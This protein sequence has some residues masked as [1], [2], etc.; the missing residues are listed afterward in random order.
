MNP[1]S[2]NDAG[3]KRSTLLSLVLKALHAG[4]AESL[5][6]MSDLLKLS[7]HVI[8]GLMDE[9]FRDDLV[10]VT[11]ANESSGIPILTYSLTATGRRLAA[12]ALE[13]NAYVGPAPVG[14]KTYRDQAIVNPLHNERLEPSRIRRALADLVLTD[15]VVNRLGPAINTCRSMLLYGPPGNGKSS[16]ARRIG[17]M[18]SNTVYVPYCVEIEGQ[19]VKIFDPAI[20]EE[21][22]PSPTGR[23]VETDIR[24]EDFD[25]RWVVCRRPVVITGG[26]FSLDMLDLRYI[27]AAKFYE[28]PL[29]IKAMGGTFVID[30]FG[31]QL[32]GPKDILNRWMIPLEEKLDYLKFITGA[33]VSLPFE[34]LVI[35]CTNLAPRD[36]MDAAFLRRIPYKIKLS[37]PSVD[38]YREI[39]RRAA[40]E[41]ALQISAADLDW[42][43]VE[44]QEQR[45]LPLG[46][47]QPG[48][49]MNHI[50][51]A[52][53]FAGRDPLI[54]RSLIAEA[55]DNLYADSA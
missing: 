37:P 53:A 45:Q 32:I 1:S 48:F 11:G 50:V 40:A 15:K 52:S 36:L 21:V 44:L 35:F 46:G 3:V 19:I 54:D 5:P 25:H 26:G 2:A 10:K 47:Y 20:H 55:L 29:H 43:I 49:I 17:S 38:Q 28:A 33:T 27:E 42:L 13:R 41:H 24:Q 6:E 34:T 51:E 7:G 31:R 12:E 14:L 39:F 9:A 16:V 8:S 18:F 23:I 30:D 22:A 4:R